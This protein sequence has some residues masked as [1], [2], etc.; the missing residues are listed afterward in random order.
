MPAQRGG[1]S[2]PNSRRTLLTA[3]FVGL[4]LGVGG[5][6]AMEKL[7]AGFT[8]P[9]QVEDALGIPVLASVRRMDKSK[10]VSKDGKTIPVPFYQFTIRSRLSAKQFAPCEAV[11]ICRTWIGRPKLSMSRRR[12]P[13]KAKQLLR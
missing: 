7:N 9:R 3:L 5:A 13:A 6:F 10:L 1:Q 11:S 2:F 12:V 4:G 8:T